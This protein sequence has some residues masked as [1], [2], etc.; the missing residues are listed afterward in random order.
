MCTLAS[1]FMV[2]AAHFAQK[3]KKQIRVYFHLH[4]SRAIHSALLPICNGIPDTLTL[5]ELKPKTQ[6]FNNGSK[7]RVSVGGVDLK[8]NQKMV[9]HSRT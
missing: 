3:K 1:T 7:I 6:E 4:I 5:T 2:L 8:S 9:G